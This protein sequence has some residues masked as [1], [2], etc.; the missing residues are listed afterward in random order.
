MEIA[1]HF[2]ISVNHSAIRRRINPEPGSMRL[3]LAARQQILHELIGY[4]APIV[5]LV[6]TAVDDTIEV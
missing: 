3:Y 2:S 5:L 6:P 4:F 1:V